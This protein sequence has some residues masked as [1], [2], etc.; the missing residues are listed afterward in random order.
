MGSSAIDRLEVF[1]IRPTKYD[2]EGYLLRHVRGVLPSNSLAC[3]HA[4]TADVAASAALDPVRLRSHLC[5]ESVEAVPERLIARLAARHT[6]RVVVALVGVQTSQMP[7]AIDLARRFRDRGIDVVIG[8]FHVSGS[9]ALGAELPQHLRELSAAGVTLVV[10]EVEDTWAQILK[11]AADGTLAPCYDSLRKL[12]DLRRAPVPRLDIRTLRRFAFR[13]FGTLDAGR[14]CPFACSFCTIINVQGRTMRHR[15][16]SAIVA[17]IARNHRELG[18]RHYFFT[19][20]NFSRHPD[21]R[22]VFEGLIELRE[23]HGIPVRFLMQVDTLSHRIPEFVPLARRAGCFQVFIGMESLDPRTLQAAGKRQ[24]HA[25]RYVELIAT[26]RAAGVLTHVGYIVG[27]P[28][29]TPESVA[30]SVGR[31]RDEL[32]VDLASFFILTPL[33]GSQD[34]LAAMRA[35]VQLDPDLNRFDTFHAVVD[36]PTMSRA[37]LQQAYLDAWRR[38]YTR[39]HMTRQ[40]RSTPERLTLLQMY[41]WYACALRVDQHHP[42]MTGFGR[43]KARRDRRAGVTPEGWL[44]HFRRRT[45]EIA[46]M[47]VRYARVLYE[48]HELWTASTEQR[49]TAGPASWFRFAREMLG[50]PAASAGAI[51]A[52]R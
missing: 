39:D 45:P 50:H 19:D 11:D 15:E 13:H 3:L 44:A 36:H 35:G 1:L 25:E 52:S 24:N 31:L 46:A 16:P 33:P 14:G 34:H 49:A 42:M 18:T 4:L 27:F 37:A 40:L 47:V 28:D 8:G 23:R 10:G 30:E 6:T 43:M 29:D 7:R 32:R 26:W 20:D 2:D 48:M 41:L 9:V 21:W 17:A 5:D 22:G 38:F 12:P 51:R